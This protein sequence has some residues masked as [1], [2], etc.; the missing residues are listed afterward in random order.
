[1]S[2]HSLQYVFRRKHEALNVLMALMIEF[3]NIGEIEILAHPFAASTDK[4]APA[5]IVA[6]S[7]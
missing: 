1:M 5:H 7:D 2:T 3:V 6:T 4:S